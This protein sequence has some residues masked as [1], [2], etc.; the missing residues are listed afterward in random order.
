[1][2][3]KDTNETK[4]KKKSKIIQDFKKLNIKKKTQYIAIII[5]L[6]VI[7]TIYFSSVA[8]KKQPEEN[9]TQSQINNTEIS[10]IEEK[11]IQ[12]LSQI[13]GVGNVDVMITYESGPEIVPAFSKD[14]Q[15][16]STEDTSLDE[17]RISITES[18]HNDIVTIAQSNGTNALILKEK[19]PA[20]KGV[21]VI[22]QGAQSISVKIS[23]LKAVQTVL[24][25]PSQ[26]VEVFVMNDSE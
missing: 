26:K 2:D 3:N 6:I 20:I 7:L 25:I 17:T 4:D 24:N 1:M 12:T 21:I 18:E 19:L 13:E 15:T 9:N 5:I 16:N 11:L 14:T 23:L 8:D 10:T 22:A